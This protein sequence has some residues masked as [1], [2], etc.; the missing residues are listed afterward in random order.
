VF[1]TAPTTFIFVGVLA[2]LIIAIMGVSLLMYLFAATL[3]V[4]TSVA[5][6][7]SIPRPEK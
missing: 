7:R 1:P 4:T 3:V 6:H 2:G 5:I